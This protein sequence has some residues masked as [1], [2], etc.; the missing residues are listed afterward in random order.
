LE[1]FVVIADIVVTSPMRRPTFF[2]PNNL[3]AAYERCMQFARQHQ[4]VTVDKL[5]ELSALTPR[6][7]SRRW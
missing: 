7:T 6:N 1:N 2:P 3:K 5:K 4:D